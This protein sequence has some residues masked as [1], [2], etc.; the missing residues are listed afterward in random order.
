MLKT[1]PAFEDA[2]VIKTE[3]SQ[4]MKC[5]HNWNVTKTQAQALGVNQLWRR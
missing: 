1:A 2:V 4:H 5:H 3:I